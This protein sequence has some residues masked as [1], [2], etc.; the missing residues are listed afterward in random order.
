MQGTL[1]AFSMYSSTTDSLKGLLDSQKDERGM[2]MDFGTTSKVPMLTAIRAYSIH[3]LLLLL[4]DNV[5]K[6]GIILPTYANAYKYT[7]TTEFH[8]KKKQY[9]AW[10]IHLFICIT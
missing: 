1:H 6:S 7:S 10:Q 5:S 2:E 3:S 9:C 8:H 4:L